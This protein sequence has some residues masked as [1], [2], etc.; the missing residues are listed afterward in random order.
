MAFN[1]CWIL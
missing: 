1:N